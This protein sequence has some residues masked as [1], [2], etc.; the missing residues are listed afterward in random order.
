MSDVGIE[1][2]YIGKNEDLIFIIPQELFNMNLGPAEVL[3]RENAK[4]FSRYIRGTFKGFQHARKRLEIPTSKSLDEDDTY[5]ITKFKV[6]FRNNIIKIIH[7]IDLIHYIF[8]EE[9]KI[10]TKQGIGYI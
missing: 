10:V 7:P 5:F 2:T 4:L 3:D 6:S 8:Q 1:P 9:D